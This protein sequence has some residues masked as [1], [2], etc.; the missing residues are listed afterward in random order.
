MKQKALTGVLVAAAALVAFAAA[1]IAGV[2][3]GTDTQVALAVPAPAEGFSVAILA[4]RTTGSDSGLAVLERAVAEINLLK[5]DLVLH[6]GDFVPGYIRDMN[7][8]EQDIQRVKAILAHL[9]APL[10]PLAGNHDVITGTGDPKDRRG[11]ELYR[12]YFGPLYYSFD[13][14]GTHFICLYTEETLESE[15]RFGKAQLDW[16]AKDLAGNKAGRIFV[17][18]HKPVWE[19]PNA[20][21]D[22]VHALLRQHPVGA[23]I[24]GHFHHY[25]KSESKDGIQYYVLGVTGARTFSPELAGGLEHYCML[26]IGPDGFRLALVKPGS[27]L[28]DDYI[29]NTDYKNM[30]RLRLLS[31]AETGVEA[32]IRSP[33]LGA[34]DGQVAV[35]VTNPLAVPLRTVVSRVARGSPWTFQPPA[36][37]LL[38]GPG[39]REHVY[40]RIRSPQV[41][42]QHLV[43]PEVEVQYTYVDGKGR[44]VPI[45]L[46]RRVPL[47]R[48]ARVRLSEAPVSLDGEA[49]EEAW[50]QAPVLSTAVW[51]TSPFETGKPGPTFRLIAAR[52]G[53]YF[54]AESPDAIISD[55]RGGRILSDALFVGAVPAAQSQ[56]VNGKGLPVVVIFPFG[57][58][59]SEQALRASWD[60]KS[61]VGTPAQGVHVAAKVLENRKGW[62]CEGIV[63]WDALLAGELGAAQELFFNMGAWD[64]D[65]D[66]FTELYSWAPTSDVT[67]WG[68]LLIDQAS[69]R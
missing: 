28:A 65:G 14:R 50:R 9:E 64:N 66:L 49:N 7:Q 24:A 12:R 15:P 61:P 40:V 51:Q 41:D 23:V 31:G 44:T 42:A 3:A 21:W 39:G 38:I 47:L 58:A 19:Y 63:P 62:R 46:S 36:Q 55:F 60:A 10:F 69:G 25:Y 27:V 57:P 8:W 29:T 17:F 11:E 53:L 2:S 18:L 26:H 30:E 48:E 52:A 43:V 34:T 59:G 35:V 13:Y 56:G 6:I 5:P 4:D 32:P 1:A 67:E 68:R 16:L 37:S 22:A 20:G 45:T 33:E 54:Y